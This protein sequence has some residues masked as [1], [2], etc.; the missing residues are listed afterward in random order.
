MNSKLSTG[1]WLLLEEVDSTQAEAEKHLRDASQP[2]HVIFA[3][4]QSQGRGRFNR[5]WESSP[6]DSLTMSLIF[7]EYESHP[8]PWLIGMA[9]SIAV[10][11]VIG[12]QLQWPNDIV[13]N[14]K[15]V[16][17]V[18]TELLPNNS[19]EKTPVI[20]VGVN[21]VSYTHLRAHET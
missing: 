11:E 6:G 21:P 7:Q 17:G 8:K 12:G 9:V 20:G 14:G 1:T 19:Q 4:H 5:K 2:P 18:L 16:S 3:R 15:K 10:A 13:I